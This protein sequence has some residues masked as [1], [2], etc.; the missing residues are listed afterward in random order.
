MTKNFGSNNFHPFNAFFQAVNISICIGNTE[1][2]NNLMEHGANIHA[3]SWSMSRKPGLF[4]V[5]M[6]NA[7][8]NHKFITKLC[9]LG[10]DTSSLFFCPFENE[11]HPSF[12]QIMEEKGKEC[13]PFC[14]FI[15]RRAKTADWLMPYLAKFTNHKI[16]LCSKLRS[17]LSEKSKAQITELQQTIP[18]LKHLA[19]LS[20][21][22][23]TRE[24]FQ[25]ETIWD[26]LPALDSDLRDYL[27]FSDIQW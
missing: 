19:R 8:N 13:V 23:A 20:V 21:I 16:R 4:P 18:K 26:A 24:D 3:T 1:I 12:E 5:A 11:E 10:L 9:Q 27:R 17:E 15:A 7:V 22:N 25:H 6:A 14:L 2:F